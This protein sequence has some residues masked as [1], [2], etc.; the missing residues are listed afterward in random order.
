MQQPRNI[1]RAVNS[2][3]RG[4]YFLFDSEVILQMIFMTYICI[5]IQNADFY[6]HCSDR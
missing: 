5:F 1:N 4:I 6:P 3:R 2:R